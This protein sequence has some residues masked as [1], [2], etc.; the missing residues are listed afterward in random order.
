V[1]ILTL[2]PFFPTARDG[3]QGC[4]VA[5]PLIALSTIGVQG[6]VLFAQPFYRPAEQPL[7]GV[8]PSELVR[9]IS[10]PGGWGLSSAGAFLFAAAL[11]RVRALHALQTI[12]VIH[13]HGPLPCG[14]A[15]ILLSQELNISYVVSVHGLDA[16]STNQVRGIPGVW[17][18]RVS[19]RV[20]RF[21]KSAICVSRH[22][23]DQVLAGGAGFRTSVVYNGVDPDLFS[24]G[25]EPASTRRSILSIG[26]LIPIKGHEKLLRAFAGVAPQL[27]DL[28]LDIVGDGPQRQPL[29]NIARELNVGERVHFLGRQSRKDVAQLLRNCTLFALPSKYE[30][31]GCVYLEAMSSGKVAIGCRGQGIEEVIRHGQNGWLIHPDNVQELSAGLSMLLS[32]AVLRD[33]IGRQARESVLHGL[34]LIHQAIQLRKVYEEACE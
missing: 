9:Y 11:R 26:N 14:H 19:Q 27:P 21:A 8:M 17:C 7:S 29:T 31:L 10:V 23:A 3:A 4:F 12:D 16:Y 32:D 15:A 13:A 33:R 6:N 20:F 2:T 22:V 24:P 25:D 5:E 1:N 34:T 28:H 30:G 18:R